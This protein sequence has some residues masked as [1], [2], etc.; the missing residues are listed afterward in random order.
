M[1]HKN[2]TA[3][4]QTRLGITPPDTGHAERVS[5]YLERLRSVHS[6]GAW[7]HQSFEVDPW[8]TAQE[9]LSARDDAVANGWD[10]TLPYPEPGAASPSPLL[11]TLAAAEKAPGQLAPSRSGSPTQW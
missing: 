9:L 2:F 5:Q 3:L 6:P 11:Q 7:F 10:G 8:S 4:L 1:G